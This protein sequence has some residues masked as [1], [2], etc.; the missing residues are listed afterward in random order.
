M[1][2]SVSNMVA[3]CFFF[4]KK[5]KIEKIPQ[6]LFE[7]QA[8]DIK[9]NSIDFSSF[10]GK[11]KAYVIV[12][13]ACLCGYTFGNYHDMNDMFLKHRDNGLVI[14]AFPCNQ[15]KS[16]EL[17]SEIKIEEYVK[18]KFNAEFQL[19]S[20]IEVN[21]PDAH[22]LFKYLRANSKLHDPITGDS[23]EIPW[24]FS[25]FL[26]DRN[27]KVVGFYY[28]QDMVSSFEDKIVELLN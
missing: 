24:N 6:S 20:K 19:F 11:N 16:Q 25:K 26:L 4:D 27:G 8:E 9:G 15:F 23:K 7:I 5:E 22:P 28:P 1:G 18:A 13:V 3:G 14:L 21:G 2:N 10:K 12:N 17:E